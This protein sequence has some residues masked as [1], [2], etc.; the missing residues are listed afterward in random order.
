MPL[1]LVLVWLVLG[2]WSRVRHDVG[3]LDPLAAATS[4]VRRSSWND[5]LALRTQPGW[6]EEERLLL[7]H[8]GVVGH[9]EELTL[10]L[11][12]AGTLK[13]IV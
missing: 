9:R 12:T 3:A 6:R 5:G 4:Q 11:L 13:L 10:L 8:R 1:L 7:V 2:S